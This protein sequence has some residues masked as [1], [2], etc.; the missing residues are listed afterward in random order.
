[1]ISTLLDDQVRLFNNLSTAY[2]AIK[3]EDKEVVLQCRD[4]FAKEAA[5][6]VITIGV[7]TVASKA[8]GSLTKG[9]PFSAIGHLINEVLDDKLA[10]ATVAVNTIM[11]AGLTAYSWYQEEKK[12]PSLSD[13]VNKSLKGSDYS[14]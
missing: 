14:V 6:L 13:L 11:A 3:N 7:R 8:V 12:K 10:V 2:T 9:T 4:N 5:G 1:M